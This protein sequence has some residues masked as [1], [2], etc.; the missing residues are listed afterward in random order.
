MLSSGIRLMS[1][2]DHLNNR[3]VSCS[4][5]WNAEVLQGH[6]NRFSVLG[7]LIFANL[8]VDTLEDASLNLE[9]IHGLYCCIVWTLYHLRVPLF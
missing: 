9:F 8:S 6:K 2:K 4:L 3:L 7:W 5:W 1:V